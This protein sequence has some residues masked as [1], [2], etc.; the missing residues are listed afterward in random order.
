[1]NADNRRKTDR[2]KE[3]RPL[4]RSIIVFAVI[5]VALVVVPAAF[6]GLRPVAMDGYT[7]VSTC[8]ACHT[9]TYPPASDWAATAHASVANNSMQ[10]GRSSCAG[11][12]A[13]NFD[14]AQPISF[15]AETGLGDNPTEAFVSCSSCHYNGVTTHV[16]SAIWNPD[17]P[18][19]T[20]LAYGQFANPDVCGQCHDQ[21]SRAVETYPVYDP[22]NP[23]TPIATLLRF[24]P[25]Y[26]PYTTPLTDV[27]NVGSELQQWPDTTFTLN[28][29]DTGAVQYDE[30]YS[31]AQ[32]GHTHFNSLDNL[33]ALVTAGY[34]PDAEAVN[35][36][37]HCMS[38]DQRILVEAGKLTVHPD[39][40]TMTPTDSTGKTVTTSDL[41]YGV[42]CVACHDPHKRGVSN[43]VW[44]G[45]HEGDGTERNAQL[46]MPRKD[47]CGSCHNGELAAGQTSFAPGAEI[48]HPTQEFMEGIGA[49]GVPQTPALHE[50]FCVQCHMVPTAVGSDGSPSVAA[51]HLFTPIMPEEA[52]NTT[53]TLN[54]GGVDTTVH[55]PYSA[56][57]TCHEGTNGDNVAKTE[58]MQQII[59]D[60]QAWTHD[61]VDKVTATLDAKAV[62][63]GFTDAADAVTD[64]DV[65]DSDFGMAYTNMELVAQEGSWGVHNWQYGVLVINKAMEQADA[66]RVPVAGVSIT[67]S[68]AQITYGSTVKISGTV[69]VPTGGPA[70][71]EGDTVRLWV[72]GAPA[73]FAELSGNG[74]TFTGIKPNKNTT[75]G[76]QFMG[77]TNYAPT[78]GST[79]AK[80]NVAYRVTVK[81]SRTSVTRGTKVTVSGTVAPKA[82]PVNIQRKV[83]GAWKTFKS[84]VPVNSKGKYQY[85]FTTKKG[86][87]TF[88]A[89]KPATATLVKGISGTVK[90]R[91]R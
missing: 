89:V 71:A 74:Y 26:D 51:N 87:Y 21:R 68:A 62:Q 47:L 19:Y 59:D 69:T 15:D 75:F 55:M 44:G 29:H 77:D 49:I 37:S 84:G 90:V 50:G 12:H 40:P 10:S 7:P 9:A 18:D 58:A 73:N 20:P 1:M 33:K 45:E 6:A 35:L 64:P 16:G 65:A 72:N 67:A 48:N 5:V 82:S 13:G 30:M 8:T 56:C 32:G 3:V 85:T 31:A 76:I 61:M 25:P 79:T 54:I 91:A 42:T 66:Y 78:I 43:S 38:T 52:M 70:L 14:P 34:V 23:D 22:A 57:S 63:M 41:K 46:I 24:W 27:I 60:R 4:R 86:T 17:N 83:N 36:C 81:V 28:V 88:R 80:V 39:N 2:K 11:C 53:T